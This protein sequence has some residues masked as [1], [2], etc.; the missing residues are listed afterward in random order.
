MRETQQYLNKVFSGGER[1]GKK[2]GKRREGIKDNA[3]MG[4]HTE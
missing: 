1:N 2:G 3:G 4:K